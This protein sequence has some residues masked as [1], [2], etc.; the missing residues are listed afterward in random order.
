MAHHLN[1]ITSD[2]IKLE[3]AKDTFKKCQ[4]IV[5]FFKTSH[6]AGAA[7]Q[8]DIA[9]SLTKGGGLKSSVKTRWSSA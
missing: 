4:A 5:S 7:L 8:E 3:F 9:Q 2:I 6:Q 1:L